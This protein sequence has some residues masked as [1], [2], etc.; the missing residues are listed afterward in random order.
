MTDDINIDYHSD[1]RRN[2]VRVIPVGHKLTFEQGNDK[3]QCI[4]I[5]MDGV[6]LQSNAEL[7]APN[8]E[9][10]A[11]ILDQDDQVIGKVK[12]RLIYKTAGRSGWQFTAMEDEVREFIETLVLD[13][14]KQSLRRAANERLVEQ[15]QELLHLDPKDTQED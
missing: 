12:A 6:A 10:E 13:T 11:F 4:D 14:Q 1:E 3:F 8:H 9:Q 2:A 7:V 5:S 15:E